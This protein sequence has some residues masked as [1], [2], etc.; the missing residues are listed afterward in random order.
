VRRALAVSVLCLA[1]LP[2]CSAFARVHLVEI[3]RFSAPIYVAAPPGDGSRVFVVERGGRIVVVRRGH[4]LRTPFLDIRGRVS[5][6]GERG[7]LSMA[8]APDYARSGR[9]YVDYTDRGGDIRVVQFRRSSNPDRALRGSAR[10]VIRIEHSR[11]SNHNGGQ[12]QFGPDGFL[13][14]GVG[15]G[16]SENDPDN[17]GQNL[18]TLLGKIL[19]VDPHAGGGYGIPSGNPFQ[20]AGQPR[21]VYAYGLRNPWRFSFDRSTGALAIGD[22]G[23]NRFEEIDYEPS[24]A[25]LGKNFGWSHFEGFSHFKSGPTPNYA[26]PVLVRSHS[27]DGFCAIVGGYVVRNLATRGLNGRYVYGDLCNSRLFS[28][29][30]RAGHASGNRALPVRVRNLVSF[31]QDASG[32]VYAVSLSGPVYRLTG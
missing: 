3:G 16:G 12:L 23:Q 9:F 25:A 27:A 21:E 28:V 8:F 26:P 22:V 5:Q 32:R 30:L 13:Y 31:G 6:G 24:G 17:R 29:R 14:I 2:A 4:K 18:G 7:L 1:L 20:G 11:F 19:R 10:N 15:D